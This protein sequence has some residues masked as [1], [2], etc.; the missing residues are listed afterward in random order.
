MNQA[1]D[2]A[3]VTAPAT[4]TP[5]AIAILLL[6]LLVFLFSDNLNKLL[7]QEIALLQFYFA[8]NVTA[9]LLLAGY[10]LLSGRIKLFSTAAPT[11][12]LLRGV[13][14]SVINLGYLFA[15]RELPVTLINTGLALAPLLITALS[16]WLLNERVSRLQWLATSVGFVGV[17]AI[18]Q[19]DFELTSIA[20]L[21]GLAALPLCYALIL[22]LSKQLSATESGWTMNFYSFVVVSLV[23]AWWGIEQWQPLSLQLWLSILLSAV[24]VIIAFGMLVYAFSLA[25]TAL[26]APFEY[27][28]ILMALLTDVWLWQLIPDA[29]M[30]SGVFF[31][32]ACGALQLL[33]A[34]RVKRIAASAHIHLMDSHQD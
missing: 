9:A 21:L 15:L 8:R 1:T 32:L 10:F 4:N 19:P 29:L 13:L 24:T 11:K 33:D 34:R 22:I 3:S 30:I 2:K 16:P 31:I 27:I 7:I 23:S 14:F 26:L 28:G 12:Q 20:A 5:Q 18:V 17:C 6:A 25:R